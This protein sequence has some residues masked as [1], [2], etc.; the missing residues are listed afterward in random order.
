MK[1]NLGPGEKFPQSSPK[2]DENFNMSE[3][4]SSVSPLMYE[5]N[6]CMGG[7]PVDFP[8]PTVLQNDNYKE[9]SS[10]RINQHYYIYMYILNVQN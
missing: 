8:L 6:F 1:K 3:N 5:K 9:E 10:P 2:Y 7:I 4:N